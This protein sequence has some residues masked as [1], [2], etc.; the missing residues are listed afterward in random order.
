MIK[1]EEKT[2]KERINAK[3]E[4]ERD[5]NNKEKNESALDSEEEDFSTLEEVTKELSL[6][7]N[8]KPSWFDPKV[9]ERED[10]DADV[11]IDEMEEYV[12]A[13][14]LAVEV[15]KYSDEL[16]DKLVEMVNRDYK[17]FVSLTTDLVDVEQYTKE[18]KE[19]LEILKQE[20]E[21]ARDVVKG[22]LEKLQ[23][24]LDRRDELARERESLEL[25][26]EATTVCSKV[27]RLLEEFSN[28][29]EGSSMSE[30]NNKNKKNDSNNKLEQNKENGLNDD[31]ILVPSNVEIDMDVD[32]EGLEFLLPSKT[33]LAS[34]E[35]AERNASSTTTADNNSDENSAL[36]PRKAS[37]ETAV[38]SS[39]S[40][41]SHNSSEERARIL[42]RVAGEVNRLKFFL[43]QGKDSQQIRALSDRVKSCD[44]TLSNEL[45]AAFAAA[46]LD[47]SEESKEMK[48]TFSG[49]K[50]KS[51]ATVKF[52]LEAYQAVNRS[53]DA[54]KTVKMT[55][56]KPVISE[57]TDNAPASAGIGAREDVS[58]ILKN[59]LEKSIKA[60]SFLLDISKEISSSESACEFL[61][62]SVLAEIDEQLH[63]KRPSSF[64]PGVP[65][66]FI[67]NYAAS[68][69]FV[70]ALQTKAETI[71]QVSAE[72]FFESEALRIFYKRWNLSVYF[73][74]RFQEIAGDVDE[75]LTRPGLER[76]KN[77][78]TNEVNSSKEAATAA[79][80]KSPKKQQQQQEITDVPGV[81]SLK[82]S[83]VAFRNALR[84]FDDDVYVPAQADKFVRLAAQIV[85]RYRAWVSLGTE[86]LEETALINA[87]EAASQSDNYNQD[88]ESVK[89]SGGGSN[90]SAVVRRMTSS[91]TWGATA[92][93]EELATVRSE[94]ELFSKKVKDELVRV[95]AKKVSDGI[96]D[97][98]DSEAAANATSECLE[99]GAVTLDEFLPKI[100]TA[101]ALI[102]TERCTEALN[103]LKGIT[104]TFRMT[105]KPTPSKHS[106]F[107]PML[108]QPLSKFC[109]ESQ[110]TRRLSP[111]AAKVLTKEVCEN[112]TKKYA[113]MAGDLVATVLKTEASLNRLKDRQGKGTGSATDA[114]KTGK[115]TDT[116]KI[117][118]QLHLDVVEYA[119]K[120]NSLNVKPSELEAFPALWKALAPED[121]PIP[122]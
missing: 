63:E 41:K 97:P 3:N 8:Q 95:A 31:D 12:S 14:E 107:V 77:G 30:N 28:G 1:E 72:K 86:Y 60:V 62:G 27:E 42:S 16:Q 96:K 23:N 105:N 40:S 91:N 57:V 25:I 104:A 89:P 117:F 4:E 17:D 88:D 64:S 67:S 9:F 33:F 103:Q 80:P 59:C 109:E 68:M 102:V 18:I 85:S 75:T 93:C 74:L 115:L 55:L 54:E 82:A 35:R 39:S 15:G 83:E 5:S 32:G 11:Y 51:A 29:N 113:E 101:I 73:T 52:L 84:C 111:V 10:F 61:G 6:N 87:A 66:A 2:E 120:L 118:K 13:E 90:T 81:F 38:A 65:E 44:E 119:S 20:V 121:E 100:T 46:L 7:E 58:E 122:A 53:N 49:T 22:E 34:A 47:A 50:L 56:I 24:A 112:V 45:N 110:R 36:S 76:V 116:D 98:E 94:V 114:S 99:L 79:S 70:E 26:M 71:S 92:G 21:Q 78:T 108:L 48:S 43:A 37:S 106:H 69:K 19:P